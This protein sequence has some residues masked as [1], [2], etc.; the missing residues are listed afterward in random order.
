MVIQNGPTIRSTLI[1]AAVY[2]QKSHYTDNKGVLTDGEIDSIAQNIG[3]GRWN[4]YGAMY[5]PKPMRDLQWEVLKSTFMQIPGVSPLIA[6]GPFVPFTFIWHN[7]TLLFNTRPNT[8]F[9]SH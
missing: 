9:Q 7:L 3:V 1:D 2:A 4:V 6:S 5:G 8:S